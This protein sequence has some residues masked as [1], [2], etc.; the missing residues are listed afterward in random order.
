M[1]ILPIHR[2]K[3]LTSLGKQLIQTTN[4]TTDTDSNV[5]DNAKL[6]GLQ[7]VPIWKRLLLLLLKLIMF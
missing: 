1:E 7:L 2:E 6:T 3:Q 4:V 5:T